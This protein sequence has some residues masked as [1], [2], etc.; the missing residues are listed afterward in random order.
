MRR[1]WIVLILA[2]IAAVPAL[3]QIQIMQMPQSPPEPVVA[4]APAAPQ[5]QMVAPSETPT[6][7]PA[8]TPETAR[9]EMTRAGGSLVRAMCVSPTLS[10]NTAGAEE[11]CAASGYTCASVEGTCHRQCT[12]TDQCAA[13]FVCD[14]GERRCVVPG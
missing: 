3:A 1:R 7:D 6:F 13:G 11:N 4:P 12:S 8:S 10:R 14:I 5:I 2:A 9:A